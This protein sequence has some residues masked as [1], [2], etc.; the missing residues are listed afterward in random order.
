[1]VSY[2]TGAA[3]WA[4]LERALADPAVGQVVLVDNGNDPETQ[5]E[6]ARHAA[7]TPKLGVLAGHGNVGFAAG[8][9]RGARVATG[10][11]LLLLNPD[12]LIEPG[13]LGALIAAV[14]DPPHPW[15]ATVRVLD[16]RGAEQRGS[17]RNPGTPGQC[18]VEALRLDRLLP[19]ARLNLNDAPLPPGPTAVPAISGAFMLM[20]R[21][22]YDALGGMDEAYFLHVEDLDFCLRLARRGGVAYFVPSLCCVHVKGTSQARA[23]TVERHKLAGF[24]RFFA[25]HFS[26]THPWIVRELVWLVLAVGLLARGWLSDRRR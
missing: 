14:D 8:C 16:E 6:L 12:C 15:I 11:Y 20:P 13:S 18:L 24:R 10:R 21:A 7:A 22:T 17:R 25:T 4:S 3:L 2:H 9:N 26:T 23:L 19:L 1:M 5:A